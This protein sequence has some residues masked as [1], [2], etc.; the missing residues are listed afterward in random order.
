MNICERN[1]CDCLEVLWKEVF[2]VLVVSQ[3]LCALKMLDIYIL[4][5]YIIYMD[6]ILS[7]YKYLVK[8]L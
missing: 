6:T 2:E 7:K 8:E 4:Y 5:I 1:K 3:S